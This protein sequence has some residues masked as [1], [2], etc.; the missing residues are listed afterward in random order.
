MKNKKYHT[1]KSKTALGKKIKKN[2]LLK[3]GRDYAIVLD[4]RIE[5]IF[6]CSFIGA[7]HTKCAS[8]HAFTRIQFL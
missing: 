7:L 8:V 6:F 5:C 1:V 3:P 4:M 2:L